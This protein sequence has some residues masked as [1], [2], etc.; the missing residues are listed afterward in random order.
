M[1][2]DELE[3]SHS[4]SV[5]A[6]GGVH[7]VPVGAPSSHWCAI[8]SNRDA[9]DGAPTEGRPLLDTTGSSWACCGCGGGE[10]IRG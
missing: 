6:H 5:A 8:E 10:R 4:G 1:H 9:N 7:Q 2:Y 3:S